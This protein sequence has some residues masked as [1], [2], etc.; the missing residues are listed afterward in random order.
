MRARLRNLLARIRSSY[1]FIPSLMLLGTFGLSLLT[2]YLDRRIAF[3]NLEFPLPFIYLTQPDGAKTLLGTVAGSM[4]SVASL[5]FSI[6]MVVLTMASSQ[7]GPR[8]IDNFMRDRSNQFVLG[9]F[10]STFL[11][12]LLILRVVRGG[13]DVD[14]GIFVPQLSVTVSL[15]LAIFNLG[16]FIYF[17]HN[18]T[19][20][21]QVTN[22]LAR[23]SDALTH[24]ILESYPENFLFPDSIG[25]GLADVEG[26]AELPPDFERRKAVLYAPRGGYLRTVDDEKLLEIARERDLVIRLLPTPGAFVMRGGTLAEVYPGTKLKTCREALESQFVLGDSRTQA[27]DLEFLFDQLLE[28][29]L[30]ALS[31][32]VNDPIT[33]TQCIDRIGDNLNLLVGRDLPSPYRFDEA[34]TLRLVIPVVDPNALV[35]HL[36]GPMR[37]YAAADYLTLDHLLVTFKRI[38]S[39][40]HDP[41]FRQALFNEAERIRDEAEPKLSKADYD[42]LLATYNELRGVPA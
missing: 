20:N 13:G 9:S 1:W 32:G 38:S 42:R 27:Q 28:L 25:L 10:I 11:Y 14:V 5:T 31:P 24:K 17:I 35:E 41:T 12:C 40:T 22:V 2:L 3:S 15:V 37:S 7:F 18:T 4:L 33:A 26:D 23:I 36:F 8:L 6:L 21:I 30:R 19:E 29:A 39:L 16:A 34:E